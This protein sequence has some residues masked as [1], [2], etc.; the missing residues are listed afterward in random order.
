MLAEQSNAE[1]LSCAIDIA[2][3]LADPVLEQIQRVAEISSHDN[4][5]ALGL[6]QAECETRLAIVRA[7][8]LTRAL[9]RYRGKW[10]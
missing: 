5:L 6:V 2:V 7:S 4:R 9:Q 10:S 8:N 3:Q 1:R